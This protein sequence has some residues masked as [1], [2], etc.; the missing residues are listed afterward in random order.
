MDKKIQQILKNKPRP[1]IGVDEVGRGCLCGPVCAAAV[2][3]YPKSKTSYYDS[4]TLTPKKRKH[5]SEEI[6][7]NHLIGMSYA[8]VEEI[9]SMNI[10]QASLLALKRAVLKL[11]LKSGTVLVDGEWTLPELHNFEQ[12]AIIKGD[13]KVQEIA[14]ASIVAKHYRDEWMKQIAFQYPEYK[15]E[16]H[17]GYP[18]FFHKNIIKRLGPTSIHRKTFS[19]VKEYL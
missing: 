5:L 14:A 8:T 11:N 1:F 16:Q 18:T 9:D 6:H 4:K 3:L 17:K 2:V 12:I 15:L 13:S 19:G 10:L 7:Q